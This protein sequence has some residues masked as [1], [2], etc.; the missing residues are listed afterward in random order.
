[1]GM[2]KDEDERPEIGL[3]VWM[4]IAYGELS[5]CRPA[6]MGGLSPIPWKAIV[7]YADHHDLDEIFVQI[8]LDTDATFVAHVNKKESADGNAGKEGNRPN[9]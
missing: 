9:A 4:L 1:M 2:V 7:D 5:T 6:G 3:D 8:I